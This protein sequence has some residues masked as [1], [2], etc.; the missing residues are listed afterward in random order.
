[1]KGIMKLLISVVC[2]FVFGNTCF[3]QESLIVTPEGKVGIGTSTPTATL[4]VN[5]DIKARG[6]VLDQPVVS[7]LTGSVLIWLTGT[8]PEGYLECDGA[9]VSRTTY[10]SLFSV[11][12]TSFGVGD[13]STTFNLPDFRGEFLRGWDHGASNDPDAASRSDSGDGTTVGDNIG[14]K[15]DGAIQAHKHSGSTNT[16]GNHS[17]S[18]HGHNGASKGGNSGYVGM[19]SSGNTGSAGNHSHSLRINNTGGAETR[20]RNISVMYIIKY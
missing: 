6:L 7:I 20:P 13:G 19:V 5:G 18:S 3:A 8:N 1:M 17:H 11:I 9:A 10:A 12:G 4:E 16:A 2:I 15:Q 14:T